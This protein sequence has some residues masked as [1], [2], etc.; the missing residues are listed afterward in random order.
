MFWLAGS[1]HPRNLAYLKWLLDRFLPIILVALLTVA[2][3]EK[4]LVL[5][6]SDGGG[7]LLY[8]L[9]T[10]FK[11][12]SCLGPG[13]G[14]GLAGE[15]AGNCEGSAEPGVFLRGLVYWPGLP[16]LVPVYA[17][18]VLGFNMS[19]GSGTTS[20]SILNLFFGV[21]PG[22]LGISLSIHAMDEVWIATTTLFV[23]ALV[24]VWERAGSLHL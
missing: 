10:I 16:L 7:E 24:L 2:A 12:H 1:G 8:A 23:L 6:R 18:A 11:I 13:V 17:D 3:V 5:T 21:F 22:A 20:F 9:S 4:Y 15:E 19:T 14:V